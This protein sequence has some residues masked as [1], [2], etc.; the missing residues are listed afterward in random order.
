MNTKRER[1]KKIEA[2]LILVRSLIIKNRS[3][4][5][6]NNVN[7]SICI[8]QG[9]KNT[10]NAASSYITNKKKSKKF[11][12]RIIVDDRTRIEKFSK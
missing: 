1:E 4:I 7:V 9:D 8:N 12:V 6:L 10:K 3:F 2:Q 11:I 5:V